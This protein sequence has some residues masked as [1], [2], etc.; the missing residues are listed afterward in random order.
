MEQFNCSR[1]NGDEQDDTRKGFPAYVWRMRVQA[2]AIGMSEAEA[3]AEESVVIVRMG[4][5]IMV[6]WAARMF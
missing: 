6:E 4:S 1:R 3:E 5:L 2:C